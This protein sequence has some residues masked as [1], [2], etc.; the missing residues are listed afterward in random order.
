MKRPT[1]TLLAVAMAAFTAGPLAAQD[2]GGGWWLPRVLE[3]A[4]RAGPWAGDDRPDDDD[5]WD[6]RRSDDD[7]RW[8]DRA[9]RGPDRADA[10]GRAGKGPPFCRSGQGH[11]VHG[12]EWCERKG[13]GG[14]YGR[15]VW[16]RGGWRDVI[17]RRPPETRRRMGEPTLGT[18]LGDIVMGRLV[19]HADRSGLPGRL[20]GRWLDLGRQGGVLQVRA[21]GAPL[22]EIADFDR[23]GRADLVLLGGGR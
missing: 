1:L 4:E 19:G 18:I 7:D 15:D 11:P 10:R 8:D 23:D 12:W 16:Q 9:R 20:D 17:F 3:V 6:D 21:G 22:A 14:G 13:W 2:D 5:R